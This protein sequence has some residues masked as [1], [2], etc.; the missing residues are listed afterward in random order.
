MKLETFCARCCFEQATQDLAKLGTALTKAI[1][2]DE[3]SKQLVSEILLFE[4]IFNQ[5]IR[6][7]RDAAAVYRGFNARGDFM[8][9]FVTQRQL[10]DLSHHGTI[11][12]GELTEAC[13]HVQNGVDI[14]QSAVQHR[15]DL[16]TEQA[17]AHELRPHAAVKRGHT[18]EIRH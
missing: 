2:S 8:Q 1:F 5:V 6:D 4:D 10:K 17:A 11:L 13:E 18:S 9:G 3:V 12:R 15:G 16:G 14:V 7:L